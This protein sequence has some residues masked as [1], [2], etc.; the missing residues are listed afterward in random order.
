MDDESFEKQMA[1][2]EAKVKDRGA[3][4]DNLNLRNKLRQPSPSVMTPAPT[5]MT[6]TQYALH[7][8]QKAELDQIEENIM[9]IE[10][11]NYGSGMPPE[12]DG[13]QDKADRHCF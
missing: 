6:P 1:H 5:A 4:L 12:D 13:N 2:L 7:A 3:Y 9:R 11:D 8:G 10:G